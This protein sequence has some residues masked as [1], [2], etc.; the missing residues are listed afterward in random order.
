MT[1][2]RLGPYNILEKIGSG[3]M[4]SVY[5]GRHAET[6]QMAAVKELTASLA[7]QEG[8]VERFTREIDSMR[9]LNHPHIVK[10]YESGLDGETY[11]YAMEYVPGETL[12]ALLRRQ[13]RIP[14]E[15]AIDFS[16]QI[17]QALK[18][19]HDAGIIH[20]D[21]KPSNLL[22]SPEGVLKLADF[23]VAQ[24]FAADR[25]TVTGGIVGTAEFMSPEQ[26][27]G[28]RATKQSDL[29]SLGSV[30]Y[31]MVTGRPPFAGETAIAILQKHKFGQ[32]DKPRLVVP[33]L[34]VWLE[35]II[36]QLL[37]KDPA[38]R[39]PDAYVLS[40]RLEQVVRKVE[41][42]SEMT[43][44]E[45]GF[46]DALKSTVAKP[47]P[48]AGAG[49]VAAEAVDSGPGPATLMKDLVRAELDSLDKTP[50]YLELF[51]HLYVQVGLLLLTLAGGVWWFEGRGLSPEQK[52]AAGVAALDKDAGDEWIEARHKYFEPLVRSDPEKWQERV[53]P[54][55][56]K[57]GL[58]EFSKPT[59][60]LKRLHVSESEGARLLRQAQ[61]YQ[62]MGDLGLAERKL[63][64]LQALVAADPTQADLHKLVVQSLEKLR[65][66]T[67]PADQRYKLVNESLA[68]AAQFAKK[69]KVDEA[70][71]IWSAIVELYAADPGAQQYVEKARRGLAGK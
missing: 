71:R 24:V 28:K 35:E 52:F 16:I 46:V 48:G 15:Q 57:I 3:G 7:R 63:K 51:N 53:A 19:A 31:A 33:D 67:G 1:P 34:P 60:A 56:Q 65:A 37:E 70:R 4:G 20:R 42:A 29:Y 25:L 39:F 43:R 17:C 68:S 66:E 13:R 11:Y 49:D 2:T 64:A 5:L 6:G 21:L 36:C 55:L 30:L 61:E 12:T 47:G 8:F 59:P 38:K 9:K 14:W 32:F 41:M 44:S 69:G 22:L 50:W 27:T 62:K 18:A 54:Y 23:G 45:G 40:R 10:L 58:Y 26:A